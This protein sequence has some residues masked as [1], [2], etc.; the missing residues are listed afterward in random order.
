MF[1]KS[2]PLVLASL[3]LLNL[4]CNSPGTTSIRAEQKKDWD[5]DV[6]MSAEKLVKKLVLKEL[7]D[8][9]KQRWLRA[10]HYPASNERRIDLFRSRIENLRGGYV[11]VGTD[12]NLTFIAWAKSDY[13]FLM[14]FDPVVVAVNR[15]HLYFIELSP[16][17]EEF[18]DLW[19]RKN[20]LK[21]AEVLKAKFGADPD[22]DL[23]QT[24]FQVAHRGS[25]DVPERLR[26]LKYMETHFQLKTFTNDP[27]D[28]NF[29]RT[30]VLEKRIIPVGGDLT[31]GKTMISIGDAARASGVPIRIV[32]TS[33]AEEYIRYP[34]NMRNNFIGLPVDSKSLLIRTATSGAK[35]FGFP[36]GEKYPDDFPFHYNIQGLSNFQEWMKFRSYL[37]ILIVL[38]NRTTLVKGFSLVDKTPTELGLKET[39]DIVTKAKGEFF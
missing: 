8:L 18:S 32:Y 13:A 29:I 27:T 37:S 25:T 22:Y 3:L 12:Q 10:D 30:M 6:D 23:I 31:A 14:D 17:F 11:G 2:I 26:D 33:N 39:G 15:I 35:S 7:D 21:S 5:G 9:P 24:A 38:R 36:D 16:T 34:E 28:Y 4:G 19:S 20:R 1:R